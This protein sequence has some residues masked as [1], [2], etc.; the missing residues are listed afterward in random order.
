MG[1]F[2][3]DKGLRG[4]RDLVN[5]LRERG[6]A[7]ERVPLSG[8]AGGSFGGDVVAMFDG[9]KTLIECKVRADGFK[10]IYGW[11]AVVDMLAIKRDRAEWLVVMPISKYLEENQ[12]EDIKS[13][14]GTEQ[15]R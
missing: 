2:S 14:I 3:R 13:I 8:A 11:L 7:A 10:Q 6:I 12:R 4:E 1:K 5:L 9:R 15:G